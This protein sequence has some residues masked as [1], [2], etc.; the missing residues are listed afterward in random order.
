MNA[1]NNFVSDTKMEILKRSQG[2]NSITHVYKDIL[3]YLISS[4]SNLVH[5]DDEGKVIKIPCWHGSAE[6]VI[7]KLKQEAN[8]ILPVISIYR[9][10]E[11]LDQNRLRPDSTMIFEKYIDKVSNRA[12]RVASLAPAAVNI[13]YKLSIWSKYQEDMDQISEQIRRSFNPQLLIETRHSNQTNAYLGDEE[14]Q[15]D[16]KI[17]DGQ[18]RV[19]RRIFSISVEGYISNPKFVITNTGKI[20]SFNNEIHIPA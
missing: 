19:I 5:L 8:I 13:T 12:V 17:S 14:N 4:F 11:S 9:E 16:I 7:A 15:G 6:R 2:S 18:D 10:T 20:E 1:Y 3:K